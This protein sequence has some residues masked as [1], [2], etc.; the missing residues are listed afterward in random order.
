MGLTGATVSS[1]DDKRSAA[2]IRER[3]VSM[4]GEPHSY[5]REMT[6]EAFCEWSLLD[7]GDDSWLAAVDRVWVTK[8]W[9]RGQRFSW[10]DLPFASHE[11]AFASATGDSSLVLP[12]IRETEAM[13]R[14][15]PRDAAGRMAFAWPNS[16]LPSG[17]IALQI[18]AMQEYASRLASA[19]ALAGRAEWFDI[20]VHQFVSYS[21]VLRDAGTGLWHL[22]RGWGA[23]PDSLCP[24]AW[25]RG[26]GWL[27]RGMVETARWLPSDHDGRAQL[28]TLIEETLRA[29]L[30]LRD[31]GGLWHTMLHRPPEDSD[32]ETSGTAL[33]AYSI[34][35][36]IAEGLID[37]TW[38]QVCVTSA[39]AVRDQIDDG[40]V[41]HRACVGPGLL[42][43]DGESLYLHKENQPDEPHGPSTA[44]Y[45]LLASRLINDRTR[46]LRT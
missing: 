20:A 4:L 11:D 22:G 39:A 24:G 41:V 15:L 30:P 43:D 26:H 32:L 21:E 18:D 2:L 23:V 35:R 25:S 38:R 13:V 10:R 19:A 27:L 3:F 7:P 8:G 46:A 1:D 12:F 29:L 40:G 37:D 45:A 31:E 16:R 6:M 5:V 9:K 17:R 34:G 44:L 28:G 33:I 36:A 42:F 14:E